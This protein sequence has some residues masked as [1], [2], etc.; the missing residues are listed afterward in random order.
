MRFPA[1]A[2]EAHLL[3]LAGK[4]PVEWVPTALDAY[5][6]PGRWPRIAVPHPTTMLKYLAGLHELGHVMRPHGEGLVNEA[7]A[8]QWAAEHIHPDLAAWVDYRLW[9]EVSA[10]FATHLPWPGVAPEPA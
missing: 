4:I 10:M 9:R 8:W 5:A 1:K 2:A 7:F 6:H 3:S